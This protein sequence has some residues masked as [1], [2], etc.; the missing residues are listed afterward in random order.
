M[1]KKR[2]HTNPGSINWEKLRAEFITGDESLNS[3]RIRHGLAL[4]HFYKMTKGWVAERTE[5][6]E[7]AVSVVKDKLTISYGEFVEK[8]KSIL[9]MLN[10]Q[11]DELYKK[12]MSPDGTKIVA[13]LKSG[14]LLNIAN[15]VNQALKSF[16]LIE[17]KT[18]GDETENNYWLQLVA[19][20]NGKRPQVPNQ[21]K[22][23]IDDE[24]E[25]PKPV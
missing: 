3:F 8:Q 20:V 16:R 9:N 23:L 15:T 14:E 7:R 4:Q 10:A 2:K 5:T 12:T 19:F 21:F 24:S 11:I 18:T 1:R 13:P 17:G 6:R 22:N 25:Q